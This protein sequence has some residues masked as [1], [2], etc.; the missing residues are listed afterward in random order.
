ML[1]AVPKPAPSAISIHIAVHADAGLSAN[2]SRACAVTLSRDI[3]MLGKIVTS[4]WPKGTG[5][6]AEDPEKPNKHEKKDTPD[7]KQVPP[8]KTPNPGEPKPGKHGK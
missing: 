7:D 3:D 4:I 5:P 1:V 2:G 6:M 8:D